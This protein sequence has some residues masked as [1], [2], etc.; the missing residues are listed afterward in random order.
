MTLPG[1]ETE[2]CC[3]CQTT[4]KFT[5]IVSTSMFG[6]PDLD[7]RPAEPARDIVRYSVRRCPSCGYCAPGLSEAPEQAQ[8]VVS[9]AQ[10][11]KQLSDKGYPE[12]AN[13]FLCLALLH[14][15]LLE[16]NRSGWASVYAA[17]ICDDEKKGAA[18]RKCRLRAIDLFRTAR[19][20]GM[21]FCTGEGAEEALLADLLRRAKKFE[22]VRQICQEGLARNPDDV[23]EGILKFQMDLAE[24]K[25]AKCHTIE[26]AFPE[27]KG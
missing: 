16:P 22:D 23:I 3:L 1:E 5:I 9:S 21:P 26:E 13:S 14:E 17:W 20:R 24:G 19:E 11:Q 18:A 2:T 10:Y 27:E 25:D 8:S 6:S 12:S 15:K 7:T 4:T